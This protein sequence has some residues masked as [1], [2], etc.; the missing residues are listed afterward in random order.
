MYNSIYTGD[1]IDGNITKVINNS[2]SWDNKEP[3]LGNPI[4]NDYVLKSKIDGT[5]FWGINSV[6]SETD[7]EKVDHISVTEDIN[8]DLLSSVGHQHLNL[9]IL[10]LTESSFLQ[11]HKNKLDFITVSE[12]VD[13]GDISTIETKT[14]LIT[15]TS[16]VNLDDIV[17]ELET[18][19]PKTDKMENLVSLTDSASVDI[20]MNTGSTFSLNTTQDFVLNAP[21][22]Y[23]A[24]QTGFISIYQ[25]AVGSRIVTL[26]SMYKTSNG[27]VVVLTTT[28]NATDVLK[29]TVLGSI[30]LL[31]LIQDIK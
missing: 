29:F 11:D 7:K 18:I 5:R 8:L 1:T 13:L 19:T 30:I 24:G 2:D 10:N 3:I 6:Y 17:T 16:A 15:V 9:N 22:N 28:P 25:D 4:I 26:D 21:T 12:S 14:D 23:V 27:S 31:E 20:D